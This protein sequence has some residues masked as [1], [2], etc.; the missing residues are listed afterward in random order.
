MDAMQDPEDDNKW[1]GCKCSPDPDWSLEPRGLV[2]KDYEKHKEAIRN[3]HL[4]RDDSEEVLERARN[5]SQLEVATVALH[6]LLP[7][8]TLS[9]LASLASK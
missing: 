9:A 3:R 6:T 4:L 1:A 2:R 5:I 7:T 8:V